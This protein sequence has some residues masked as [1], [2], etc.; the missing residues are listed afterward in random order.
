MHKQLEDYLNTFAL[1]LDKL[2]VA[3]RE[4]QLH[5]I[6]QHLE[7]SI[8]SHREHGKPE[9]EAIG[10][11]IS[12]F[13]RAEEIGR[14]LNRS[15]NKISTKRAA[16]SLLTQCAV[17][18]FVIYGF[19]SLSNDKPTDFPFHQDAKLVMAVVLALAGISIRRLLEKKKVEV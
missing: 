8:A 18:T 15:V 13:G 2:P 1:R 14:D 10:L 7:A 17:C 9:E 12:Q 6:Q 4:E 11:A 19:F 16:I 3:Q 5:E